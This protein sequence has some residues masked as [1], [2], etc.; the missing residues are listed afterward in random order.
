MSDDREHI[1]DDWHDDADVE[2]QRECTQDPNT[3]RFRLGDTVELHEGHDEGEPCIWGLVTVCALRPIFEGVVKPYA[4]V[5]H[6]GDILYPSRDC[7]RFVREPQPKIL[8]FKVGDV[9]ECNLGY[10]ALGRIKALNYSEIQW[11]AALTVPYQIRLST[12]NLIFSPHDSDTYI[13]VPNPFPVGDDVP[14]EEEQ[15]DGAEGEHDAEEEEEDAED[16]EDVEGQEEGDVEGQEDDGA[17]E[18]DEED[19]EPHNDNAG[20]LDSVRKVFAA[21]SSFEDDAAEIVATLIDGGVP[22]DSTNAVGD[23]ALSVAAKEG[24]HRVCSVLLTKGANPLHQNSRGNT[25][26]HLAAAHD[27]FH[28]CLLLVLKGADT[29]LVNF[30]TPARSALDVYGTLA[31]ESDDGPTEEEDRH[32]KE[33]REILHAARA[34]YLVSS[35]AAQREECWQRRL[36]FLMFVACSGLRPLKGR[37]PLP[38]P[39][40]RS[41]LH[42]ALGLEELVRYVARFL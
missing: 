8:R 34:A 36:G 7:N 16:E 40:V 19:E 10:W 15:E 20:E 4:V 24:V 41:A 28:V 31:R 26:L 22:V 23:T 9:V 30:D 13:R 29:A 33:R 27:E 1:Y 6:S 39:L 25:G 21:C 12:G 42:L 32:E 35:L 3:L 14:G 37:A 11:P 38:P 17:E 2:P 18:S 5:T